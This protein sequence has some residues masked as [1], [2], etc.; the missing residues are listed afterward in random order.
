MSIISPAARRGSWMKSCNSA[1]RIKKVI[2][3]TLL[4]IVVLTME[5]LALAQAPPLTVTGAVP[6]P[7]GQ[8]LTITGTNFGSRPLV[9]L[10][11]LPVTVQFAV[12]TQIVAAVPVKMMPA[13]KYLLTVSRGTLPTD[14]AS[15]QVALG[16]NGLG[17]G[18]GSAASAPS[19][20]PREPSDLP[21]TTKL[22]NAT[23]PAAQVGD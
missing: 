15:I 13:G 14:S 7:S 19:A 22:P 20:P 21:E 3:T 6:D 18:G 11:L 12:D 9:T 23:D 2:R 1:L 16:G 10:D 8:T 4:T 5:S 17:N